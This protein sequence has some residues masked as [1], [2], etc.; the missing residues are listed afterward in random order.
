VV[1]EGDDV[2]AEEV[3]S[4]LDSE[5]AEASPP[6]SEEEG[7]KEVRDYINTCVCVCVCGVCV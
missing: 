6:A 2:E 3:V 4:S 7:S 1:E 5:K